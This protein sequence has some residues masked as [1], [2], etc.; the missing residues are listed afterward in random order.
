MAPARYRRYPALLLFCMEK[1]VSL[2]PLM[3]ELRHHLIHA[4]LPMQAGYAQ[5][6][7]CVC[8][9]DHVYI[10]THIY[11]YM[12][13]HTCICTMY[14]II[15]IITVIVNSSTP[16]QPDTSQMFAGPWRAAPCAN[17][18][19]WIRERTWNVKATALGIGEF[20]ALRRQVH[21]CRQVCTTQ[22]IHMFVHPSS[23]LSV[24][25]CIEFHIHTWL[26]IYLSAC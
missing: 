2:T 14:I 22:P 9:Y 20:C 12:Y 24:C 23:C 7:L 25:V 6:S 1:V 17:S 11:I 15:I 18:P 21:L 4:I 13:T 19:G 3:R 26:L 8:I 5:I 10:H 16:P